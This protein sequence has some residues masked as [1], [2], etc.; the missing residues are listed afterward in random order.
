[1]IVCTGSDGC[2]RTVL[3]R[4]SKGWAVSSEQ[5]DVGG[6][7]RAA[8]LLFPVDPFLLLFGTLPALWVASPLRRPVL[9]T[10]GSATPS[11]SVAATTSNGFF[12][13]REAAPELRLFDLG[14]HYRDAYQ[15][16]RARLRG[17]KMALERRQLAVGTRAGTLALLTTALAMLWMIFRTISG[18]QLLGTSFCSIRPSSRAASHGHSF[19]EYREIYRNV[20]FLENLLIS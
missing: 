10:G 3:W 20:L 9:T 13:M 1:M 17:E 4:F 16:L 7:G 12:T 19:A 15:R 5:P 18:G 11:R 14:G 2:K 8:G 6:H